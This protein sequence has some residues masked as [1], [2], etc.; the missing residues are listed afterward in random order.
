MMEKVNAMVKAY[1]SCGCCPPLLLPQLSL[2]PAVAKGTTD[3]TNIIPLSSI[4]TVTTTVSSNPSHESVAA[5][6]VISPSSD[7][8]YD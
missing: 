1:C 5:S 6:T 3:S 2:P 4:V 7:N 8:W